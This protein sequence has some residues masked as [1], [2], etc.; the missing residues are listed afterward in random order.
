MIIQSNKVWIGEQWLPAQIEIKDGV[1]SRVL[2]H[3]HLEV[4]FD[5]HDYRILPGFIDTHCHGAL[6]FDTN[7]VDP[8]G[9]RRWAAYLPSEGVTGFCPTTITQSESILTAALRNVN[10]NAENGLLGAQVLGVHL[11]GPYLDASFKG[12]QPE[13]HI[14][15]PSIEQFDRLFDASGKRIKIVT[16]AVEHDSHYD[17]TRHISK[18]GVSVNIGHSGATYM[19][20]IIAIAN[21]ASGFTHTF[22]GMRSLNHREPGTAGAALQSLSSFTEII[23]DGIHVS[24]PI[25]NLLYRAKGPYHVVLVTD[26][27]QAKGSKEGRYDFGG[28]M[29][30]VKANGGAYIEGTG[31]LA[32]STL[33]FNE[34]LRNLI[35][36]AGVDERAAINSATINPARV[37]RVDNTKGKIQVGYDADII[38]IDSEYSVIKA[39]VF[40][41]VVFGGV[42]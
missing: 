23:A 19:Q 20:S 5:A 9:L 33:K 18:L 39:F 36:L 3:N 1:I 21:G 6:G 26:A 13:Q 40:G 28:Q 41:K 8:D 10:A 14:V 17:L 16:L 42:N 12:A 11:E 29:I 7:N 24:W 35:E 27:L 34:G 22:N 25:I 4:D 37:L 38:V 30:E 32:G 15:V 2:P 31:G